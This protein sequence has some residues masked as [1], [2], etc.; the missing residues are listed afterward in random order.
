[1]KKRRKN[2]NRKIYKRTQ[3]A[4][5]THGCKYKY[6]NVVRHFSWCII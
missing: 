2:G 5:I 1:M 4:A 3:T 6:I